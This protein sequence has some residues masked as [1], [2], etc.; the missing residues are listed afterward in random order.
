VVWLQGPL[1]A[2]GRPKRVVSESRS[3]E[4]G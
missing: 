4:A 1:V 3:T 2:D